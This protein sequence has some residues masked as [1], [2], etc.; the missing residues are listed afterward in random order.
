[1]EQNLLKSRMDKGFTLVEV[2]IS[3]A[4]LSIIFAASYAV[5]LTGQNTWFVGQDML[6]LQ[7]QLR[8]GSSCII[9]EFREAASFSITPVDADDDILTFRTPNEASISYYRDINDLNNDSLTDQIIREYPSGTIRVIANNI[10]SLHF[11]SS[12]KLLQINITAA[13]TSRGRTL[14]L[15]LAEKVIGRNE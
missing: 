6:G 2:L 5:L 14:Q 4:I 10:S 13:K 1:V 7:S 12:G 9:R 3:V 11:S 8:L 15:S